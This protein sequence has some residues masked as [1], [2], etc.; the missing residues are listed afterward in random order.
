MSADAKNLQCI[1]QKL[2]TL[3]SIAL[4]PRPI[5]L[6]FCLCEIIRS[7]FC[8]HHLRAFYRL[9]QA[10]RGLKSYTSLLGNVGPRVPTRNVRALSTFDVRPTVIGRSSGCGASAMTASPTHRREL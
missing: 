7:T 6:H 5:Q 4:D 8:R 1:Q 3:V 2:R 10:C 9:V